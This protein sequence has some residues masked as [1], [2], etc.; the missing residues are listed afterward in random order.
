M[1]QQGPKIAGNNHLNIFE[2]VELFKKTESKNLMVNET[3]FDET[4]VDETAVDKIAVDEPGPHPC[5]SNY[6][7][8]VMTQS[9]YNEPTI[10]TYPSYIASQT[11]AFDWGSLRSPHT[12]LVVRTENCLYIYVFGTCVFHIY[13]QDV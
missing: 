7:F 13:I 5:T 12:T 9:V 4:K 2:I 6:H 3:G 10:N 1:A 11:T 8:T